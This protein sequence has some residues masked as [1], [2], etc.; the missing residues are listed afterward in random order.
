MR[1]FQESIKPNEG[2]TA[3][4]DSNWERRR[5]AWE[6]QHQAWEHLGA[7]AT[8]LI[9]PATSL[10]ALQITVEQSGKIVARDAGVPGNHS[11]YISFNDF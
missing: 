2:I 3:G 5:Q 7:P 4:L 11:Y 6:H 10:G 1:Q 8:N 9:A